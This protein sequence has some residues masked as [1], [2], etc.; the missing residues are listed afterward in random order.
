MLSIRGG[1]ENG[2][3]RPK[4]LQL[5]PLSLE[6]AQSLGSSMGGQGSPGMRNIWVL[7]EAEAPHPRLLP[8]EFD[9]TLPITQTP[10]FMVVSHSPP[11]RVTA[12]RPC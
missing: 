9:L 3:I 7:W 12:Q 10:M 2:R 4:A 6:E 5:R 1:S 8:R 11:H